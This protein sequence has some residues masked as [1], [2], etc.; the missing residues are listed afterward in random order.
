MEPCNLRKCKIASTTSEPQYFYTCGRP[1]R[2]KGKD[3][4]VCDKLASEWVL[5]IQRML[6]T[7][8]IMI[9]SLLGRKCTKT[10]KSEFWPYSFYGLGDCAKERKGKIPFQ[11]WL[12]EQH[13]TMEI[14]VREYPTIDHNDSEPIPLADIEHDIREGIA[15]G[16]T[17]VVMDSAGVSRTGKVRKHMKTEDEKY[18][19]A[20]CPL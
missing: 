17:V 10:G 11:E 2:S 7:D 15:E 16:R 4:R 3:K 14:I 1:G 9:V 18:L 20:P 12:N 5:G 6:K 19:T 13:G 8:N